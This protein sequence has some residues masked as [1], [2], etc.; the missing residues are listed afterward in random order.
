MLAAEPPRRKVPTSEIAPTGTAH[1]IVFRGDLTGALSGGQAYAVRGQ[2]LIGRG[3]DADI[4]LAA[5]DVSRRHA[6]IERTPDGYVV[7]DAGS[8]SRDTLA[9]GHEPRERR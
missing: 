7:S 4:I 5:N 3:E 8:R 6:Q 2:V 1:L 9:P